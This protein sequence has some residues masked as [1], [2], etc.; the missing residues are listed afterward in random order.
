MSYKFWIIAAFNVFV[1]ASVAQSA[2][3]FRQIVV[4][5]E[6]IVHWSFEPNGTPDQEL[7][8]EWVGK[9][10][11]A[12]GATSPRFPG[13]GDENHAIELDGKTYLRIM[14]P[15]EGSNFDF[16]KGDSITIEAWVSPKK[17]AG[18][19]S[20]IIGKGRTY[21][22]GMVKENHNWSLRLKNQSG[23]AAISFLFRS[24]GKTSEYHRW[25]STETFG[26]GNG[27]HHVAITYTFGEKKSIRGFIDGRQVKGKW[28]LGGDTD[29][30]PVVDDDEVW[31]GSAMGGNKGSSF[32]GGLDEIAIY[33][34]KL[35]PD[36][37]KRRY[38]YDTPPLPVVVVP[39]NRVLVQIFER[40]GEQNSFQSRSME[41]AESFEQEVFALPTLPKRYNARGVHVSRPTPFL[42]HA[43]ANIV[44]PE[45]ECRLLFRSREASRLFLDGE[46]VGETSF[47]K[48]TSTANGPIWDL[49]RSH[50]PNIRP[51]QRG[52]RQQVITVKGD[53]EKH[54]LRHEILVGLRGRRAE[55]GDAS[56]SISSDS[57]DFR[58]VSFDRDFELTES[59]WVKFAEWDRKRL[60]TVNKRRRDKASE[61][62]TDYWN[63]RHAFARQYANDSGHDSTNRIDALIEKIRDRT[64]VKRSAD[65]TDLEFLRRLSLDVLGTVPSRETIQEFLND[66]TA[67]RRTVAIDRLLD[68]EGWADHWVA[69]WQDVLAENPNIVNPTLNNTGPFRFWIHESFMENKPFDRF[70]TELIRMEGAQLDGGPGGFEL[71]TANDVPMAAKSHLVAQAFLG[72]Q[73][74]CARCH[75]A[76]HHDVAQQDLFSIAAMLKRA[77]ES[78]PKTSSIP[79]SPEEL[80]QMAV[81]VTLKP[82]SKVQP[83][84][85]FQELMDGTMP[86]WVLRDSKDTREHLAAL[87]TLPANARFSRVIV[88][89]LW[90][91]Y[92]GFGLVETVEDWEHQEPRDERLLD[93]LADEFVASGYDV[94]HIARL[95][96]NSEFYQQSAV[97]HDSAIKF[98]GPARRP[99]TAEQ[100]VDSLFVAS[101]KPYDAG[102]IAFD[103]DGARPAKVSLNLGTPRR[104]WM[105]TATSNE[106]DRPGLAMPFAQPFV[107]F[108]EQFGWRGARQN[109]VTDRPDD[110][111]ALQPA[112]FL[113]GVLARRVHRLS[114]D[115]AFT[116]LA[117]DLDVTLDQ[118]IDEIYLRLF[119]RFPQSAERKV[120]KQVLG[121][122]FKKRLRLDEPIVR[123][124]PNRR[125]TVSW[126]NH[127]EEEATTIKVEL[128][129]VVRAGDPP[130]RR[131]QA[132]WRERMED[133][134][135][136]LLSSPEFRFAP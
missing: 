126:S 40:L 5:D 78:V 56:V 123:R 72:I 13:F 114:D 33:R 55:M 60:Q 9:A 24:R 20:Y 130:T 80:E 11:D 129:Q 104:S 25:E 17:L 99:L 89:R 61:I 105:F 102:L 54:S 74:Q 124:A 122:G 82:G 63:Q 38:A 34:K 68:D 110:L 48:I 86:D 121:K 111:T 65:L 1:A 108:L 131:L 127:L 66:S 115:H 62:E 12:S 83:K 14:D 18:G 120:V 134:V 98:I 3:N 71:A 36:R 76:P 35:S 45:G 29:K 135:W 109:P 39:E 64:S 46:L 42:I 87:I 90:K 6:P 84:W 81:T 30:A 28:D 97:S 59:G 85:P 91:R 67:S 116:K 75:D 73:M 2:D 52:D 118:L 43:H 95:I 94:R 23:G 8:E 47:Y 113:N 70:V 27:W 119:T 117:V 77:P 100:L 112:E 79:L 106:R 103:I 26:V 132:D 21:L 10:S 37:I 32:V 53:G 4:E 15:G 57:G 41:F 107:T 128:E 58:L 51:L 125:G 44:L 101:E 93:W 69:Y 50:G 92:L 7:G 88:N 31:I 22:P 19:Y 49:D 133:V 136:S 16:E 96:F